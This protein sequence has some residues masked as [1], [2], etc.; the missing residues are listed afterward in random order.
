MKDEGEGNE[1]GKGREETLWEDNAIEGRER[2]EQE[3]NKEMNHV[4]QQIQG[5]DKGISVCVLEGLITKKKKKSATCTHFYS[6]SFLLITEALTRC[7]YIK[8][9]C[10]SSL[11]N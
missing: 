8:S 2:K 1:K 3:N 4:K 7:V 5:K 6:H 11:I 9:H 10:N